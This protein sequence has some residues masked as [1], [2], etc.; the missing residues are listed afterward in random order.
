MKYIVTATNANEKI[1]NTHEVPELNTA[2]RLYL[3]AY[4]S[5][6]FPS[7]VL[8]DNETGEVL[9]HTRENDTPWVAEAIMDDL[10]GAFVDDNPVLAMAA[11]ME[12]L[13]ECEE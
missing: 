1:R 6:L 4:K 10:I 8:C 5:D 7:I 3:E 11:L 12:A 2:I 13:A 9:M